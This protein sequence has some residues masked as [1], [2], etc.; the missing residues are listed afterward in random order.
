MIDDTPPPVHT[1]LLTRSH[2]ATLFSANWA[3]LKTLRPA[4]VGSRSEPTT[5]SA[6]CLSYPALI[7]HCT[8]ETHCGTVY[9]V[10]HIYQ[11]LCHESDRIE[12]LVGLHLEQVKA[13]QW[14]LK[15]YGP[16]LKPRF[17][18]RK[19]EKEF[20]NLFSHTSYS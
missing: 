12:V 16:L 10:L 4:Y 15:V 19:K 6:K 20:R 3:T 2:S 14:L 9:C 7:K 8:Q 17:M 13:I 5:H 1:S 18:S 11:I